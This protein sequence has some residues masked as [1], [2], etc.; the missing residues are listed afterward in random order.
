VDEAIRVN[1]L[2]GAYNSHDE[3]IKGSLAA[4]KL[5]GFAVLAED[6]HS[7][8]VDRIKDIKMVRTVVGGKSS[9][10][11]DVGVSGKSEA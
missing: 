7:I 6:P 2:K 10:K 4:E 8:P 9:T 1:T 3:A 5:A 11:D